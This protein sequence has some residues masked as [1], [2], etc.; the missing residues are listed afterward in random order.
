MPRRRSRPTEPEWLSFPTARSSSQG[1]VFVLDIASGQIRQVTDE[2]WVDRPVWSPDGKSIA[3]LSY[4]VV[5]PPG[6]YWFVGPM[7]LKSQVRRIGLADG[8]VE[9]LTEP[10]FVHAVAFLADGRP[11]WSVVESE[12]SGKPAMSRLEVL[13]QKGEV[14]TALTVEGVVDRIAVDPGDA[15]GLYLRLYKAASLKAGL[16]PQ[17][18]R[19]AYRD[20]GRCSGQQ[21]VTGLLSGAADLTQNVEDR[22]AGAR[23]YVAQLSNP[24]PRPA[25]GTAKGAIYLGDK[26]K[27]WR[28]DAATGKRDEVTFSA[29]IAFEFFPGS[30]PPALFGKAP[31]L[32]HEHSD[33]TSHS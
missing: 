29:D 5:G 6:N 15:R 31:R 12:S 11:V 22:G 28:V 26:G 7:A 18:E 20:A 19:L 21:T 25:F 9:T 16:F 24:L 10:G 8:K 23:V 4:Q 1:N 17:P 2:A 14:T 3:Y 27:L 13:S 33:S 30:P 32:T